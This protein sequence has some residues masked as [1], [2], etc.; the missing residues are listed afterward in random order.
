MF[1]AVEITKNADVSKN[2]YS[3]YGVGFDGKGN[4]PHPSVGFGKNVIILGVDINSPVHIDNNKKDVLTLGEDLTQ[5]LD[6]TALTAE[7]MYL[8]NFTET[9]KKII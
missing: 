9:R 5:G 2:K 6:G 1:G 7:K 4:F 8:I 3:G